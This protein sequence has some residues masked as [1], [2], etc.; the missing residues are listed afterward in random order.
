MQAEWFELNREA[1]HAL[2][3]SVA[4]ASPPLIRKARL[5]VWFSDDRRIGLS[6]V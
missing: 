1:R 6:N 4:G 3:L 2:A 5:F